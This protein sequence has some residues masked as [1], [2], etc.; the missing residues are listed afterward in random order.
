M[1]S[2]LS[3]SGYLNFVI[4]IYFSGDHREEMFRGRDRPLPDFRGRDGMN[5][6]HMGP[7]HL[8]M[9]Q[10]DM[11]RMDGPPMRGHDMDPRDV[12][13]RELQSDFFR[14]GEESDF[15]FRR[16]VEISF[17]EK[18]VNTSSFGGPGRNADVGGRNM[19]LREPSGRFM[20][21]DRDRDGFQFDKPPFH[22]DGRRG[23]PMDRMERNDGFRERRD[24]SPMG[25][26]SNDGYDMDMPP[27]ERRMMD[28]DRRGGPPFNLR[29]GF[30]SDRDFRNRPAPLSDF[31][32]RG[33]SPLRFGN[34]SVPPP[35]KGRP[36]LPPDVC[37]PQR[38]KDL[39]P[40]DPGDYQQSGDS[41]LTDYRSGEE[42]TLAEEWKKRNKD[43]NH[44]VN[45]SKGFDGINKPNLSGGF[46]RD[47]N[48]R[49]FPQRD[50]MSLDY[51]RKDFSFPRSGHFPA[52]DLPT[53]AS[54][55]PQDR[56]QPHKEPLRRENESKLWLEDRDPKYS[57]PLQNQE[58]NK[59]A[60]EMQ[61]LKDMSLNQGP[62]R[63]KMEEEL[64]FQSSSSSNI[65][66]R[67]QDYRDIDYRTASGTF[68][69]KPEEFQ[70]P[71]KFIKEC[72][73]VA[74]SRFNVSASQVCAIIQ[75]PL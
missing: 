17:R 40:E 39:A 63:T 31:R 59:P 49:D 5:M 16:Q 34:D 47:G 53:S 12:G 70:T 14:H 68:D 23:F 58:K 7:R 72:K 51:P 2:F 61:C 55:A 15:P 30:D 1:L 74:P 41:P 3:A 43:K 26:R 19:P 27:H 20:D 50:R 46:G 65:Q 52:V 67:D 35:D 33:Q 8:D 45:L 37:G 44:S 13:G 4:F 73:P 54:K 21:M 66:T 69:F 62:A 29:G 6:G 57:Q 25:M 22:N 75:L 28:M 48:D 18:V 36:D 24:R 10:I 9:P 64:E 42:M 56:P 32:G 11:R 38:A 60:Q 71:E